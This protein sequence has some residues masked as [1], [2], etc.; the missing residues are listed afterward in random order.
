[1]AEPV[2]VGHGE[3]TFVAT[4]I[5]AIQRLAQTADPAL[6]QVL[7]A[8]LCDALRVLDRN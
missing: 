6:R 7:A 5:D 3:A 2:R 4:L 1:M 8:R